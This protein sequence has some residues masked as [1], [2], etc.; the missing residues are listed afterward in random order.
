MNNL[1]SFFKKIK[2]QNVISLGYN[3]E[4][5]FY[6]QRYCKNL[7][8]S[9]FSWAYVYSVESLLGA[10]SDLDNLFTKNISKP[11]PLYKDNDFNI[12]FHGN[13]PDLDLINPNITFSDEVLEN[14]RKNTIE[15]IAYLKEKFKEVLSSKENK[16]LF[17]KVRENDLDKKEDFIKLYNKLKEY[18]NNFKLVV[19][20]EKEF[21]KDFKKIEQR[22]LY[23]RGV[24]KFNPEN[25]SDYNT[26]EKDWY[27]IFKEFKIKKGKD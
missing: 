22:G 19:I 11:T 24:E 27:K 13:L 10:L 8:S 14:D 16:I 1:F 18:S 26:Y 6:I 15:K 20:V 12:A 7:N 23:F 3:C 17:Y 21:L 2:F 4:V 9:L 5:S 25:H